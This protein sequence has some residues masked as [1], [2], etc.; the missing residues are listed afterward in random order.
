ML[1]T[2][3][4]K[5]KAFKRCENNEKKTRQIRPQRSARIRKI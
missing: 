3:T 2:E 4:L 5:Y 1:K